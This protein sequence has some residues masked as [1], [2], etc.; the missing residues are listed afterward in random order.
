MRALMLV[1]EMLCVSSLLASP[2]LRYTLLPT[3]LDNRLF[4]R[5]YITSRKF[6]S[7]RGIRLSFPLMLV[8][9]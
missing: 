6:P 9:K 2:S 4:Y 3:S 1:L 5:R 7:S 8:E